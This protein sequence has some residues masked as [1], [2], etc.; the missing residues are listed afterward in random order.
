M[1]GPSLSL[2]S[3]YIL[4]LRAWKIRKTFMGHVEKGKR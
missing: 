3:S 4:N 1:L 2:I